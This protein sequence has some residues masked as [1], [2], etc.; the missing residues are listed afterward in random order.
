M[1]LDRGEPVSASVAGGSY[2]D[3][4]YIGDASPNATSLEGGVLTVT[5]NEIMPGR[6]WR[7]FTRA[8]RRGMREAQG[9]VL[10]LRDCGGGFSPTSEE[11]LDRFATRSGSFSNMRR[12][13]RQ[14]A[15]RQEEGS[16]F[17]TTFTPDEAGSWTVAPHLRGIDVVEVEPPRRPWAGPLV[18][19]VGPGTFSACSNL[20]SWLRPHREGLI[21]LGSETSGGARRLNAGHFEGV[22]LSHSGIYVRV[23]LVQ[24]T[25]PETFGELGRGVV[26]DRVLQDRPD[27]KAD[28]VMACAR[29]LALGQACVEADRPAWLSDERVRQGNG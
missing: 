16:M 7:A 8:I 13:G 28:E 26:P 19:L 23:P 5:L 14:F 20:A 10:D 2:D 6:Q 21:V 4:P 1:V 17:R 15:E 22:L 3:A 9:V 25:A 11:L 12:I 24:F 29:A 18:M 27:T